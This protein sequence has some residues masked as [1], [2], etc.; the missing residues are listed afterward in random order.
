MLGGLRARRKPGLSLQFSSGDLPKQ[1]S[2]KF[3]DTGSF[4]AVSGKH[5]S[6]NIKVNAAGTQAGGSSLASPLARQEF[7]GLTLD[8]IE[9]LDELGAGVGGTVRLARHRPSGRLLALKI[10]HIQAKEQRHMLLNE[11]R[12]LCKLYHANLVP[13]YDCFQLEGIAYLALKYMDGGSVERC[14]AIYQRHATEAGLAHLGLPEPVLAAV[15]MQAL[16]GLSYL[17]RAGHVHRDLKPANV[18][19][20]SHTGVVALAD[21]GITKEV[22][23]ERGGLACSFVGTAAYMAPER[24][25]AQDYSASADLWSLGSACGTAL[26]IASL[27][28]PNGA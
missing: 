17:H 23:A 10:I 2:F 26:P 14:C 5:G 8:Q 11:L 9:P 12:V 16:C 22:A 7:P 20:H 28:A 13:M 1:S 6:F 18:L 15:A 19:L 21:F 27:R 24:L 3:T 4:S 25:N